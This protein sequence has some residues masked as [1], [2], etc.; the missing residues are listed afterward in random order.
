MF[1]SRVRSKTSEA[2]A[3]MF[4]HLRRLSHSHQA[5]I[6]LTW[7]SAMKMYIA[8]A[9]KQFISWWGRTCRSIASRPPAGW[10]RPFEESDI[11]DSGLQESESEQDGS[12]H[13][14]PILNAKRLSE[15]VINAML[16]GARQRANDYK[17]TL[18]NFV[19][20][21]TTRR[22]I[23]S[24]PHGSWKLKDTYST[25]LGYVNGR[26]KAMLLEVNG[27]R[28]GAAEPIPDG[29]SVSGEFGEL[30]G[31]PFSEKTQ[32]NG[33]WQ[34]AA[35]IAGTSTQ[36]F[37]FDVAREHSEFQVVARAATVAS[38]GLPGAALHRLEHLRSET[39]LC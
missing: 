26:E 22:L 19:C 32:A 38:S 11:I 16:A 20:L 35:D 34:G 37:Q 12:W 24:N 15:S 2:L 36:V 25:L 27:A 39:T 6:G 5:T 9:Q 29:A 30:L 4:T 17:R 8:S 3:K 18:P 7:R 31:M 1:C 14:V 23:N 13:P 21:M 28:A 33:T 10:S